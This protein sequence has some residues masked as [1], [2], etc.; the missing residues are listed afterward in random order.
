MRLRIRHLSA[1]ALFAATL[2][3]IAASAD[4]ASAYPYGQLDI[5]GGRYEFV[6]EGK[7]YHITGGRWSSLLGI[8][9]FSGTVQN[10]SVIIEDLPREQLGTWILNINADQPLTVGSYNVRQFVTSTQFTVGGGGRAQDSTGTFRID[11][12]D[13]VMENGRPRLL[14]FAVSFDVHTASPE[15]PQEQKGV[16]RYIDDGSST[17]ASFPAV[18]KAKFSRS[19]GT[20]TLK[21]LEFESG[22]TVTAD[23]AQSLTVAHVKERTIKIKSAAFAPGIHTVVVKNPDGG[24]SVP[25]EFPVFSGFQFGDTIDDDVDEPDTGDADQ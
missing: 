24:E 18:S 6:T 2:F 11:Q 15:G 7:S 9:F 1:A 23:G 13:Y 20:L 5:S 10:I 14:R 12:F 22:A 21:G 25:Y 19:S 17:P 3:V 16:Y 8:E 4:T